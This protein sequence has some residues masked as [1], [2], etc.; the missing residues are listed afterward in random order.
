MSDLSPAT[1][2]AATTIA[3][4]VVDGW[5]YT[6]MLAQLQL[7]AAS[8][9]GVFNRVEETYAYVEDCAQSVDQLAETAAG[10]NVDTLTVA[11]HHEAAQIMRSCLAEAKAMATA[12]AELSTLFDQARS[13]HEAD[14]GQV[15]EAAQSMTVPMANR[16][17]YA[18]R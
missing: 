14:Y 13:G 15:A 2:S 18:N 10:M 17:F 6:T 4:L 11:E 12:A 9:R 7:A 8:L 1:R 5:R 3:G 16:A